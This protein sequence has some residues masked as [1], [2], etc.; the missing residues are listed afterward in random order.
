MGACIRGVIGI[1]P[2]II[3]FYVE[4]PWVSLGII[5]NITSK[6]C[7]LIPSRRNQVCG[8]GNRGNSSPH[9][10]I[11]PRSPVTI[12][13]FLIGSRVKQK[14]VVGFNVY[15]TFSFSFVKPTSIEIH[16]YPV[17]GS[18]AGGRRIHVTPNSVVYRGEAAARCFLSKSWIYMDWIPCIV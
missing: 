16:R 17:S 2:P 3:I 5:C 14:R 10:E 6:Y 15:G 11:M 9:I 12:Y 18:R 1:R 8:G 13:R 7:C 4:P